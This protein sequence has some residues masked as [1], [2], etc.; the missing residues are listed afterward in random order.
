MKESTNIMTNKPFKIHHKQ[1]IKR[2][3]LVLEQKIEKNLGSL[4]SKKTCGCC[5]MIG[6]TISSCFT[7]LDIGKITNCDKLMDF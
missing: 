6:H 5:S 4:V 3:K 1:F 2:K 7:R